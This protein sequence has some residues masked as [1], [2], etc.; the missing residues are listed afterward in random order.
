VSRTGCATTGGSPDAC[1]STDLQGL[2]ENGGLDPTSTEDLLQ[3]ILEIDPH[4]LL[5]V[6]CDQIPNGQGV[7]GEEVPPSVLDR[8]HT[9]PALQDQ[10]F[11]DD[12][13]II[14]RL[15]DAAGTTINQ[16]D[17]S[18]VVEESDLPGGMSPEAYREQI[19]TNLNDDICGGP[20]LQGLDANGCLGPTT[21]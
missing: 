15:E 6:P 13:A 1:Y 2:D 21:P 8:L 12:A 20:D 10:G 11:F 7:A 18:V 3:G 5:D 17:F 19:R 9:E 16:D 14:Q 4:A